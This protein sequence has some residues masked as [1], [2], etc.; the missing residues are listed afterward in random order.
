KRRDRRTNVTREETPYFWVGQGRLA[1][2]AHGTR[3]ES[4]T[5]RPVRDHGEV[6]NHHGPRQEWC[7]PT[8]P[9]YAPRVTKPYSSVPDVT[10]M[11][12]YSPCAS[13]CPCC[14]DRNSA[15]SSSAGS[16]SPCAVVRC[17]ST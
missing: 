17:G 1:R 12:P 4:T 13:T 7:G 2:R 9:L 3:V 15:R 11:A 16:T 6:D 8:P 14:V 10:R 5:T